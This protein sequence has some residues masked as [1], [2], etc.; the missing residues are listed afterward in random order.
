MADYTDEQ[1]TDDAPISSYKN[2][3]FGVGPLPNA[4]LT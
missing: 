3:R 2:D 4:F 1:Y